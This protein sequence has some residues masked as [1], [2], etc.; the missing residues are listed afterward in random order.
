MADVHDLLPNGAK[1]R[2]GDRRSET[3]RA[4][5]AARQPSLIA[6]IKERRQQLDQSFYD[7]TCQLR[8]LHGDQAVDRALTMVQ[9]LRDAVAAA[10][11]E[12]ERRGP[13]LFGK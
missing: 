5:Q 11:R 3:A 7:Y 6:E 8:Q 2:G 4:E 12:P 1:K 13:R 9:E 10:P